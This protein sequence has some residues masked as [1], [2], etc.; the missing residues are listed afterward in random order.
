MRAWT[1]VLLITCWFGLSNVRVIE[2]HRTRGPVTEALRFFGALAHGDSGDGIL[3]RLR[4]S[5]A[6]EADRA[7]TLAEVPSESVLVPD[8]SER[9][10]LAALEAVLIYHE[11]LHVIE[12][13]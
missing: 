10:K 5:P 12:I 6:S 13:Q 7:R 2:A 1:A 8:A 11:R 3:R 9:T 4:P